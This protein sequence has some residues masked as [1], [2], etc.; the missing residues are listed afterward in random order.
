MVIKIKNCNERN[1]IASFYKTEKDA[2]IQT[3]NKNKVY[4]RNNEL[5]FLP[6]HSS[7]SLSTNEVEALSTIGNQSVLQ[8]FGENV[9]VCFDSSSK[10]NALFITNKCNSSCI[11]CPTSNHVRKTSKVENINDLLEI[12]NLIPNYDHHIT[13]TG[14]E[15]FLIRKDIFKLFEYLKENL[16]NVDYLLLTNG[17]SFAIEDYY[18]ALVRTAPPKLLIGIPIH[19]YD[20]RTH[21]YITRTPGSFTQTF[22]GI[23]NIL[24]EGCV[25]E[26]RIVVSKLNIDFIDQIARLIIKE[27]SAVDSVKFIGLEMLGEARIHIDD[28]WI[29]YK[30]SFMSI[31][32]AVQMIVHNNIDVAIYNY[33]LCCVPSKYWG[34]CKKSITENK[35]KYLSECEKCEKKDACGGMFAGTYKLMEG[36]IKA[37]Q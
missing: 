3:N 12:C 32:S 23:K 9:I 1:Y 19:G 37:I 24:S 7:I 36:V 15:P 20:A 4:L 34:L 35:I 30:D 21:D 29:D 31:E 13:I 17:R 10:D 25:V 26:L 6:Q 5:Y 16:Y 11:M 28:V 8:F 27:F 14:G 33:P 2:L 18:K 22:N